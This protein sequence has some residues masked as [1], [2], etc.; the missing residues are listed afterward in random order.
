MSSS[1]RTDEDRS[2][3][4]MKFH[5]IVLKRPTRIVDAVDGIRYLWLFSRLAALE[6]V[7]TGIPTSAYRNSIQNLGN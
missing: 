2:L 1:E 4:N 6:E 7:L 3:R 5:E